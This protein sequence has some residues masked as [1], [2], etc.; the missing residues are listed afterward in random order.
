[1]LGHVPWSSIL[2]PLI[3]VNTFW[4]DNNI[5]CI[6]NVNL[7]QLCPVIDKPTLYN[8]ET[9]LLHYH[10]NTYIFIRITVQ[11]TTI[12]VLEYVSWTNV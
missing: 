3:P 8:N 9:L 2:C 12:N 1:M 10:V 6:I 5:L 11:I 4:L 7:N